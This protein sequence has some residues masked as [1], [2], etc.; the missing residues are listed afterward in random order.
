MQKI[1]RQ[2]TIEG[3]RIPGII[4]NYHYH[5]VNLDVYED[6]MIN[7]WELVDLSGLKDKLNSQWIVPQVPVGES[8]SI[9]GLGAYKVQSARWL[10]NKA[11]YYRHVKKIVK[12]L[13]SMMENIYTISKGEKQLQEQRKV[14][15]SPKAIDFYVNNETFYQ[16]VEGEGFSIFL[17]HEKKNYVAN[18]VVYKDG[19]VTCYTS[20]LQ[21]HYKLE[22]M[23]GLFQDGTFFTG[24]DQPT[25]ITFESLGEITFG[26]AEFSVDSNEKYKE[27][28]DTYQKLTGKQTTLEQCRE[29][30]YS[31]LQSPSEQTRA[32]L[33]ELYELVPAHER[34]FLGDM[35]SRDSDYIRII[36]HPDQKREV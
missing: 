11:S 27:L 32:R 22:D 23:E 13:N 15:Y 21:L 17:K 36:Y 34:I 12:R 4:Y 3:T 1:S 33:K 20:S 9:H 18:L 30:Y 31:Y 35:D 25:T 26:E 19:R 8:L 7:G 10:F 28:V 24:F 14:L 6:G 16:T 5:Y 2:R 29:A